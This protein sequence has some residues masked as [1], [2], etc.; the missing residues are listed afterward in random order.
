LVAVYTLWTILYYLFLL[1]DGSCNFYNFNNFVTSISTRLRI[2]EDDADAL[3]HL[4]VLICNILLYI[5]ICCAFVGQD[6]KLG[7]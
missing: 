3:K 2:S 4:G 7:L 6:N 1:Y 5:Y